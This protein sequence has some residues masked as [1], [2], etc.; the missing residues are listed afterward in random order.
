MSWSLRGFF[1][2]SL[3]V[4]GGQFVGAGLAGVE[5]GGQQDDQFAGA[6][7]DAVGYVVLDH[8]GEVDDGQPALVEGV[9]DGVDV[10]QVRTGAGGGQQALPAAARGST[11][12][13][14][15]VR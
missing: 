7:A 6:V 2:P 14:S 5:D 13:I 10:G 12:L 11:G 15:T 3:V 4:G 8:P 1:L 9:G